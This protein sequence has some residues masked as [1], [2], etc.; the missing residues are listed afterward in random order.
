MNGFKE[1]DPENIP[2]NVFSLIGKRWMLIT[3]GDSAGFNTMTASW[4]G[5][6]VI[7]GGPAAFCF[8]RP[9]RYT[10]GFIERSDYYSLSFFGEA[11]RGALELCGS[12]SGR[13]CDKV[14]E[15]GLKPVFA[16]N[17]V[18]FKQAELVLICKKQLA[19]LIK[20]ENFTDDGVELFYPVKDYHKQY[21]GKI[22][23]ALIKE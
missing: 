9:Q 1:I 23:K 4:G 14:K 22:V 6:G 19:Q 20:P 16:E 13:D 18:F 5:L 3:A 8:I 7:W 10:F 12:K 2:E 15:A 11:Q 17:T 21:I